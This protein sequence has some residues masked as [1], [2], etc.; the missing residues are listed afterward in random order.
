MG[1][2]RFSFSFSMV[3]LSSLRSSLVPTRMMGTLGQWCRTSGYHLARTFSNEAGLT[4]EKHIRKT[5]WKDMERVVINFKQAPH[6]SLIPWL[7]EPN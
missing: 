3:S 7:E 2:S 6:A 5:S 4:K 1:A